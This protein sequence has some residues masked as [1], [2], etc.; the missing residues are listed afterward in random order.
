MTKKTMTP[1][2]P[3]TVHPVLAAL[4]LTPSQVALAEFLG[5]SKQSM[6]YLLKSARRSPDYATPA[7]HAV[8]IAAVL[9]VRPAD[10]RPDVFDPKWAVK[11]VS[12]KDW[13]A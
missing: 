13:A 9:G 2:L 12:A 5:I 11:R 6:T 4:N 3:S 7:Q 1:K 8:K 10:I